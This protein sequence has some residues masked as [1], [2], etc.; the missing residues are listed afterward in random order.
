M[1][2]RQA[3]RWLIGGVLACHSTKYA[4]QQRVFFIFRGPAGRT[5]TCRRWRQVRDL[6]IAHGGRPAHLR[7]VRRSGSDKR[8]ARD[9]LYDDQRRFGFRVVRGGR[10]PAYS[11]RAGSLET[12]GFKQT[13]WSL[14]GLWPKV[15]RARGRGTLSCRCWKK[16]GRRRHRESLC[17]GP[18]RPKVPRAQGRGILLAER[19]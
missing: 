3:V 5:Y 17:S 9:S 1:Y 13:F 8:T 15:T 7:T 16:W 12:C 14:L 18:L 6:I 11:S 2:K 19:K 10:F 4:S